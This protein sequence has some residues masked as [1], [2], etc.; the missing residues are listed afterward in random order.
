[1][2]RASKFIWNKEMK[3]KQICRLKND[4]N[5]YPAPYCKD[6]LIDTIGFKSKIKTS[7]IIQIHMAS[8]NFNIL[9]VLVPP[10]RCNE[11]NYCI[12]VIIRGQKSFYEHRVDRQ[13][14]YYFLVVEF[15]ND[16]FSFFTNSRTKKSQFPPYRTPLGG[17]ITVV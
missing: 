2:L 15:T 8:K 1:M 16:C 4:Q 14:L 12:I 10:R 9:E 13:K 17:L 7:N 11:I 3:K 6:S 5:V